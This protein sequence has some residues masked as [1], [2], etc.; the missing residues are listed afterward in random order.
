[1]NK[2]CFDYIS[3]LRGRL[4]QALLRSPHWERGSRVRVELRQISLAC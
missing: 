1:M 2:L 3:I 4:W